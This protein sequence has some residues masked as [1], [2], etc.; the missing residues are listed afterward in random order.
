MA[1]AR[2]E[3]ILVSLGSSRPPGRRVRARHRPAGH[4]HARRPGHG[5]DRRRPVLRPAGRR[6]DGQGGGQVARPRS[7]TMARLRLVVTATGSDG[8]R[9]ALAW[10][11]LAPIDAT[12][13]RERHPNEAARLYRIKNLIALHLRTT[14]S[15]R[16]A[17][18]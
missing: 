15:G 10:A 6:R 4:A 8:Y 3:S 2:S 11:E 13:T 12:T 9:A 1:S 7:F 18:R 16:S 14:L 5:R 17:A